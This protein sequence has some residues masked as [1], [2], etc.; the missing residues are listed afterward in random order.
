MVKLLHLVTMK[1]SF[2]ISPEQIREGMKEVIEKIQKETKW[3][4]VRNLSDVA[5]TLGYAPEFGDDFGVIRKPDSI[6]FSDWIEKLIPDTFRSNIMEFLVVREA[7]SFFIED[8]VIFGKLAVI[9]EYLQNILSFAYLRKAYNKKSLEI[10]F[11]HLRS[12]FLFIPKNLGSDET[13]LYNKKY[14]IHSIVLTQSISYNLLLKSYLD[15]VEE[16][17][18]EE[19]DFEEILDYLIRYLSNSPLEIAAPIRLKRKT[20]RVLEKLVNI[21]FESSTKDIAKYLNINH[22]TVF[23]ELNKIVSRYNATFRVEKNFYLLGLNHYL[24]IVKYKKE[25]S[26][27]TEKIVDLLKSMR[28]IFEIFIGEGSNFS[29]VYSL[30]LCPD[31]VAEYL[32]KKLLKLE[33]EKIIEEFDVIPLK[34]RTFRSAYI[35]DSFNPSIKN[36]KK[37]ID[38]EI[39]C[40]KLTNWENNNFEEDGVYRFT[41]NEKRLLRFLSIYISNGIVNYNY[42]RVF[43][44]L[45]DYVE[46]YLFTGFIEIGGWFIKIEKARFFHQSNS[47][48]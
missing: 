40:T 7:F 44:V 27:S 42:Y 18:D 35:E 15:F 1:L 37:L 16:L 12:R 2:P 20:L 26:S 38:N 31:L 5:I 30:T 34:N 3:D 14:E 45:F 46:N 32:T 23:R 10:K 24:I 33:K 22:T 29:Y 11:S 36:F 8:K 17:L 4:L 41:S 39:E 19:I 25:D 21:G 9:T 43:P 47:I 48:F 13:R 28:Y 6:I